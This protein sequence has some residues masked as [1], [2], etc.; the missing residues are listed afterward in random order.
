MSWCVI[1]HLRVSPAR[2]HLSLDSIQTG[3]TA[4]YISS[5]EGHCEIVRILLDA[6]ADP[7]IN[8]NVSCSSD[9]VC[10]LAESTVDCVYCQC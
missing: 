6:K 1:W 5:Q 2:P 8:T 7:N 3:S 4:L 9:G 10:A